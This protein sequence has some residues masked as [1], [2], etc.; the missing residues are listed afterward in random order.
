V[1]TETLSQ[2]SARLKAQRERDARPLPVAT[3]AKAA[4]EWDAQGVGLTALDRKV[5]GR[6]FS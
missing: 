5:V 1:S 3:W 6:F 2:K 4:A